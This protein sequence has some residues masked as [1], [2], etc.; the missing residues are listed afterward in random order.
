MKN[1]EALSFC[2]VVKY[3]SD[4]TYTSNFENSPRPCHNLAFM[5]EG[6]AIITTQNNEIRVKKGEI[7]FIPKNSTYSSIWKADKTC[8]YQSVHFNFLPNN[9]PFL[10]K[11]TPIQT[12]ET[13]E[14][15]ELFK[16][17]ETVKEY[18]FSNG[19][20]FFL[21]LS[22]FYNLCSKL[23]YKVKTE[24]KK[25]INPSIKPAILYIETYYN[26]PCKVQELANLCYLSPS[27]FFY[28][29]KKYIGCSPIVYKN[30][31]AIQKAACDLLLNKNISIEQVAYENGFSNPI[32]FRRLFKKITG[33]TP[34]QY[35]KQTYLN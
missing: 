16:I 9:D 27:R 32:Y 31:V 33:K 1:L 26:K 13:S 35:R 12:I 20:N 22:A 6:E 30:K 23:L 7:L 17:C 25:E 19:Y 29:F 24:E 28:L 14:F 8:V 3:K 15:E 18:Q 4:K 34:S 2:T 5:L 11:E 10:S 21:Y